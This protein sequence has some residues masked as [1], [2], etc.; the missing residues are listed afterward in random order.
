M[1]G[2]ILW[3]DPN[4][5]KAVIWC[6]DHG[7]LAFMSETGPI[8]TGTGFVDV[9]D[10]VEFDV[11]TEERVRL[12]HNMHLV[13]PRRGSGLTAELAAMREGQPPAA[14]NTAQIIPFRPSLQQHA[15]GG[16]R[17]HSSGR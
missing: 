11:R 7:D 14:S 4:D 6:E 13:A 10:I 12:A 5:Q 1:I 17:K 9:G 3:S 2:V 8:A 16:A 15:I